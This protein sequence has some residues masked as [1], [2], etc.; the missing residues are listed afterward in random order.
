[1]LLIGGAQVAPS[2]S[3]RALA[4]PGAIRVKPPGQ[5]SMFMNGPMRRGRS[6]VV[7]PQTAHLEWQFPAQTNY[8]GPVIGRDGT[9]Y[10]G[11]DLHQ[12]LAFNPNGVL[13]WSIATGRAVGSTPAILLDGRIVFVDEAGTVYVANPDGSLS[14]TDPTG[15]GSGTAGASPAIGRD[16]TIYTVIGATVFAF[17]PDGTIRWTYQ[18]IGGTLGPVAVRPDGVVYVPAGYLYA[19]DA[20]GSLLW[21]T[22][23]SLQGLASAT[24]GPN[25]TIYVNAWLPT[26]YAYNPDGTLKWSYQADTCCSSAPATTP[27]I[28][29]DG[30]I[31]VGEHLTDHGAILA[32]SPA[33]TLKWEADYGTYGYGLALDRE[34][35]IYFGATT[36]PGPP[37]GAVYGL[38]PDGTLK[39]EFDTPDG[40]YV[41]TPVAIGTHHRLYAGGLTAFLRHRAVIPTRTVGTGQGPSSL[42]LDQLM[43][44]MDHPAPFRARQKSS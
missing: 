34:G 10:Q 29:A 44:V 12:L 33:G 27:A 39:W 32:L 13:K 17:H 35:T 38:N 15:A 30:T 14:W 31:Y 43:Q 23:T 42:G 11:T 8:G 20:D 6:P 21:K 40:T 25:Q 5:W 2:G 26:I 37:G 24:V 22:E 18:I 16:G 1:M 3:W 41:R 19:I 28:G 9:I 7:G 4:A 36:Y